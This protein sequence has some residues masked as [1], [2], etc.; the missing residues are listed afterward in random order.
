MTYKTARLEIARRRENSMANSTLDAIRT[1]VRRLT[2]SP[3]TAQITDAEIDEYVNTFIVYDFPE[4]LRLFSLRTSFTFYTQPGQDIYPTDQDSF[5]GVMGNPLYNFKNRYITVHPPLY[6]AG[7]QSQLSQSR[8]EF[9]RIYPFTNSIID[10]QI[11]GDGIITTFNGIINPP[12]GI[13]IL[14]QG[15]TVLLQYKVVL[16]SVD[17]N[18]SAITMID[19]PVTST[20]YGNTL[21]TGNLRLAGQPFVV[22]IA[23]DPLNNVNYSTGAFTVTFPTAPANGEAIIA[24]VV[25]VQVARP[26]SVLYYADTFTV[27]PVPDKVY[28]INFDVYIRPTELFNNP[29]L[30]PDLEQWWQWISYGAAKKI[31]ED[32]MDLESVQLIMPEYKKQETLVLRR[33]IVQQ[34]NERVA[35][36]YT[37]NTAGAY[38]SGW[39]WGGGQF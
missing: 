30:K 12:G 20:V 26:L 4:H 31:F 33:T 22:Q 27:R 24:E 16:S 2:R 6:I 25:P 18:G 37:D 15:G 32:R 8:E 1:K 11:T 23:V 5:A 10:T 36:I 13:G 3:S 19:T 35:T 28:P 17:I 29:A 34:T 9:F 39:F 7:Y 14:A 21:S 38:G